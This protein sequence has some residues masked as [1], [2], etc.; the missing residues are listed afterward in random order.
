MRGVLPEPGF[1]ALSGLDQLRAFSR[2]L[3]P[4]VPA[5]HLVGYRLTQ[6]SSGSATVTMPASIWLQTAS[7]LEYTMLVEMALRAAILSTAPP[8]TEVRTAALS[9][10]RFRPA[11]V[12]SETLIARARTLSTGPTFTFAE[13][14]VED[15]LGRAVA[16]GAAAA[17]L[18]PVEPPPPAPPELS[19]P[20]E[21]P[22]YPTPDPYL[23]PLPEGVAPIA[24]EAL[25]RYD[26]LTAIRM[27]WAGEM[28]RTP[29]L[30]L[31]NASLVD[32]GEGFLVMSVPA[33][34]WFCSVYRH[35]SPG[36]LASLALHSCAA[37]AV[38]VSPAGVRY[39]VVRQSVDLL[40]VVPADGRDVVFDTRVTH[41][42]GDQVISSVEVSDAD[43]ALTAVGQQSSVLVAP[44]GRR[45]DPGQRR[46]LTVLFTDLVRSTEKA[47]ELGDSGW[48]ELLARHDAI[49]RRQLEIHQGREVK[50]TGDGFLTSFESPAKAVRC[51][52]AVREALRELGLQV[53]AGIHTGECEVAGGDIA[54]IAV[55]LA[56]R[57]TTAAA[58]GEIL[59]SSTVCDLVSGSG[60][61]FDDRGL[62]ELKGVG[63][64]RQLFAYAG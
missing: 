23:R 25:D 34:E 17:L 13:C 52:G 6:V 54:G 63:G 22:V 62:H 18:H 50:T 64:R 32:V 21:V 40:R 28:S 37:G 55:H 49:V 27:I 56:A 14:L 15:S 8:A 57:I 4:R 53:R 9:L 16:H 26:G 44:E 30:T 2:R 31:F 60:L 47:K 1:Y 39:G 36:I 38:T 45:Q 46:L 35:V 58:P 43:G 7:H 42:A 48:S 61:R 29:F 51:A 12:E 33:S 19:G 11:T 5:S 59:V 10:N 24:R 41:R 3:V 20:A